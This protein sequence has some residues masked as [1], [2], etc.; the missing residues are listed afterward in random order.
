VTT[1]TKLFEEQ[2]FL[3]RNGK[4]AVNGNPNQVPSG[5][6]SFGKKKLPSRSNFLEEKRIF[7]REQLL[8]GE[9]DFPQQ[10]TSSKRKGFF[11]LP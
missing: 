1:P 7:P 9:K 11:R 2:F 10:T 8:E 3:G 6:T 4:R 5:T